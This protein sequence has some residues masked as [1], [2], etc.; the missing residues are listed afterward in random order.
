VDFTGDVSVTGLRDDGRL[1]NLEAL[2]AP[3][4][5]TRLLSVCHVSH[6]FHTFSP[7]YASRLPIGDAGTVPIHVVNPAAPTALG[8]IRMTLVDSHA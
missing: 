8:G 7:L 2:V 1:R 6:H 3:Q 5:L 4:F